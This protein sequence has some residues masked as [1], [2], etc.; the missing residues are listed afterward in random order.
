MG[1]LRRGSLRHAGAAALVRVDQQRPAAVGWHQRIVGELVEDELAPLLER[2]RGCGDVAGVHLLPGRGDD[3]GERRVDLLA[4]VLQQPV[5]PVVVATL[6]V[7]GPFDVVLLLE[8]MLAFAD[9]ETLLRGVSTALVPGGRFAFTVEDGRLLTRAER[10]AMPDADT[11][12]PIPLSELVA[13]LASVGLEVRW[14]QECTRSHRV[15]AD[16]LQ[17]LRAKTG[18][19]HRDR[20]LGLDQPLGRAVGNALEVEPNA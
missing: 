16:A 3:V 15:V 8:T 6:L 18:G 14:M 19:G 17:E 9:K 4:V 11:V 10:E 1:C 20:D 7:R 13:R 12:W 5:H 2:P